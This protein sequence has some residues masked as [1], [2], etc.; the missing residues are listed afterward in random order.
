[1]RAR[2]IPKQAAEK[3]Q[4]VGRPWKSGPFGVQF[5]DILSIIDGSNRKA[6]ILALKMAYNKT[7]QYKMGFVRDFTCP[8]GI[9]PKTVLSYAISCERTS[10]YFASTYRTNSMQCLRDML[11]DL[12]DGPPPLQMPINDRINCLNFIAQA[13]LPGK[14][15]AKL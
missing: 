14:L 4:N 10:K 2:F 7:W 12:F 13:F 9:E 3:R 15:P 5:H 1:V 8:L 11:S 6:K